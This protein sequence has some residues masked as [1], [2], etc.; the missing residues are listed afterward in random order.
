MPYSAA[1][2]V[3]EAIYARLQDATLLATL[4]GGVHDDVPQTP[5]YP[6]A[7]LE[8]F[9][10]QDARGLGTGGLPEIE[11]RTH[12][13]S[14]FGGMAQAQEA[15]RLIVG[16]LKDYAL[17]VTGYAMCGHIFY[18]ETV[19]LPDEEINGIKC[20]EAV[21]IFTVFVEDNA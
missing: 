1:S 13:F 17:T 11:F 9:R 2:P 15:N 8:M 5:T 10:E 19:T 14:Q 4:T 20:H 21:S 6:F 12:V 18:R 7:W 3:T 16:L